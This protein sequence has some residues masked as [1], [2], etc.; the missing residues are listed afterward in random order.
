VWLLYRLSTVADNYHIFSTL[1]FT[2]FHIYSLLFKD[3]LTFNCSKKLSSLSPLFLPS[4][5][6]SVKK[7]G[8][9]EESGKGK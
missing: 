9:S 7:R 4:R 8:E 3:V 2:F 1:F 6:I 5:G